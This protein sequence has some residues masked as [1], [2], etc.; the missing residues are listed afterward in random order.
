M[1]LEKGQTKAPPKK[2]KLLELKMA[3]RNEKEAHKNELR[4]KKMKNKEDKDGLK[5]VFKELRVFSTSKRAEKDRREAMKKAEHKE[6]GQQCQHGVW[7][8]RICFPHPT[9]DRRI[10]AH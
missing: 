3:E 7:R 1:Q 6:T 8:C 2:D 4:Q 9:A 10:H 5:A